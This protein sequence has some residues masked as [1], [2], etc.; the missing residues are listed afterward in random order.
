[1]MVPTACRLRSLISPPGRSDAGGT[2]SRPIGLFQLGHFLRSGQVAG[3]SAVPLIPD[4]GCRPLEQ[5]GWASSRHSS[6]VLNFDRHSFCIG[7]IW[8]RGSSAVP[9][10]PHHALVAVSKISAVEWI[11]M[12]RMARTRY[13]GGPEFVYDGAESGFTSSLPGGRKPPS[14]RARWRNAA[15]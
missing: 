11:L 15:R 10:T 9:K 2:Q 8:Q 14:G 13:V 1:L 7:E 5:P 4:L 6:H 12:P 3:I